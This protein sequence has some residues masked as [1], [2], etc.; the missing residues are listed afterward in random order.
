VFLRAAFAWSNWLATPAT[1]FA[2]E[3][4]NMGR[5]WKASGGRG[6][7]LK[8]VGIKHFGCRKRSVDLRGNRY[9]WRYPYLE[10]HFS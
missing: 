5:D 1:I 4:L 2:T 3:L 10:K 8:Q 7:I 9:P 6:H